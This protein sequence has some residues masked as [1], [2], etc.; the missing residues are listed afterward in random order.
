M[1][2]TDRLDRRRGTV[3][4]PDDPPMG[5]QHRLAPRLVDRAG[6]RLD[7]IVAALRAL[8]D[9]AQRGPSAL[10]GWSRL[11]IA[12]HLRYGAEV[13]LR[14]TDDALAGRATAFYPDGRAAQRPGTLVP[15]RDEGPAEVIGSLEERSRTLDER[16][17]GLEED[18]WSTVV[19]EPAG[20]TDLGSL[21]LAHH[22]L[23]RLTE[24]E[25][26]GTDLDV[27]LPDWSGVFIGTAL[28]FRL[29]RLDGRMVSEAA[30][31]YERP[32][33]L[34]VATDGPIHLVTVEAGTAAVR[35]AD[36]RTPAA[37]TLEASSRD[38][39]AVLLG[40]PRRSAVRIAGDVELGR[41]FTLAF[42]GP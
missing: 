42:P 17:R 25:V 39:L 20:R 36:Q 34:L 4:D 5:A 22:T 38:L 15:G 30:T 40:R 11:T 13:V 8:D 9:E 18:A 7:E 6:R 21:R 41:R 29:A 31:A 28:P 3:D 26:H 12:C 10:P 1:T 32:S 16:W 19:H 33:W 37:A 14:M 27:G 2:P 23:L 35:P 24:V